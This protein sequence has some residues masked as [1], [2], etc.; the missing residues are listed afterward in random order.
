MPATWPDGVVDALVATSANAF[1]ASDIGP[2]PEARRVMPLI[3]VGERT[4]ARARAHGH[5]GAATVADNAAA[6]ALVFGTMA[7]K[8]RRLVYL[9]GRDR[10]PDAEAALA[11]AGQGFEVLEVYEARPAAA[12]ADDAEAALRAQRIDAVLHYS[13]RSASLFGNLAAARCLDVSGSRHLC[14]SEDVA[15]ALRE[16]GLPHVEGAAAPNEAA[17]LALLDV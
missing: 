8:P 10:K 16:R 13:R 9:A 14:L 6:L 3:L 2:A 7:R 15:A 17:L 11:I 5:L 12:L 1:D 4:A